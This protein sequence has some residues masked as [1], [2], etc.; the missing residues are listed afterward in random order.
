MKRAKRETKKLRVYLGRVLRD[1]Q[2]KCPKPGEV[3]QHLFSLANRILE[4]KKV[5]HHKVYSIH[6]PEVEYISKGEVHKRYEFGCK[7]VLVSTSKENWVVAADAIHGNPYDGHT[8]EQSIEQTER[9][10]G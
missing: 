8:L 7:V 10:A 4:E 6:A 3:L 5:D 1:L 9:V 2:R